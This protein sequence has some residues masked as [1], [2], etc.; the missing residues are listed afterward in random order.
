ME[1]VSYSKFI[2]MSPR[3]LRL[4]ARAVS[5]LR[6]DLVRFQL[7]LLD[8]DSAKPILLTLNSAV[9][10]ATKNNALEEK[11]LRIKNIIIEEG[12]RIK[13][14]DKSHSARFARGIKQKRMS[15]IK[16]VLTDNKEDK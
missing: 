14:M 4:V 16:I 8:K 10:N 6:L 11:S 1:I 15:H 12:P 3:K 13:R 7:S 2:K 5:H 9:A